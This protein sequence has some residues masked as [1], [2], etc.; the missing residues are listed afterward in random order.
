M[1][2]VHG[3][4]LSECPGGRMGPGVNSVL[5]LLIAVT[6]CQGQDTSVLHLGDLMTDLIS[7]DPELM[8]G[9]YSMMDKFHNF[10]TSHLAC[11]ERAVCHG[12]SLT[13]VRRRSDGT[14]VFEKGFLRQLVDGAGNILFDLAKPL[15]EVIG[16]GRV[17][18]NEVSF[19]SFLIQM[20]DSAIISV[21]RLLGGRRVSRQFE[22][23]SPVLSAVNPVLSVLDKIP[24]A[25]IGNLVDFVVDA[26]NIADRRRGMYSLIRAGGLG[27]AYGGDEDENVCAYL[28]ADAE[29]CSDGDGKF[30]PIGTLDAINDNQLG[31]VFVGG[32]SNIL[33]SRVHQRKDPMIKYTGFEF[34]DLFNPK[35]AMCK[36]NNVMNA[37]QGH[38]DYIDEDDPDH[39][40][41]DD[42]DQEF[43]NDLDP[44]PDYEYDPLISVKKDSV[45]LDSNGKAIVRAVGELMEN[46]KKKPKS[47]RVDIKKNATEMEKFEML[48]S[49]YNVGA[50]KAYLKKLSDERAASE[51][52]TE[53]PEVV[54][55]ESDATEL[56]QV[57]KNRRKDIT[58][59][60]NSLNELEQLARLGDRSLLVDKLEFTD[61][62]EKEALTEYINTLNVTKTGS[63]KK[64]V[65]LEGK[66][67]ILLVEFDSNDYR[68]VVLK[69]SRD[70]V[71]RS[72]WKARLKRPKVKDLKHIDILRH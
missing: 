11:G 66:K 48:C 16:L 17:A 32:E 5:S 72:T 45:G 65:A 69:A 27:Y 41:M 13:A 68:D 57:R 44:L 35:R 59:E 7:P 19:G 55:V 25:Y 56:V 24:K 46:N 61:G 64:V 50:K 28:D 23:F 33:T 36:M 26:T 8:G 30:F 37:M 9:L 70:P 51:N 21:T 62:S 38:I 58:E 2:R 4:C 39:Y 40:Y 49:E 22:E 18:R 15:M 20:F 43:S 14:E 71:I 12:M 34:T 29:Q 53:I 60:N 47:P 6:G 63:V 10:D 52:K 42:I 3:E 31:K 67:R 1:G 54:T